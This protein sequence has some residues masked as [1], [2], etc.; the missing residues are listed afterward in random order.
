[1]A[2]NNH[3]TSSAMAMS[4][5]ATSLPILIFKMSSAWDDIR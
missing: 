3:N 4:C 2:D 5:Q 1:V